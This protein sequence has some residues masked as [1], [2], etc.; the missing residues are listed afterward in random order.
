MIPKECKTLHHEV[1]LG[2]VIGENAKSIAEEQASNY[3]AGYVLALD[4]TARDLQ[5]DARVMRAQFQDAKR[6]DESLVMLSLS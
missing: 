4:M 5:N 3:I 2:V 1:E 6:S